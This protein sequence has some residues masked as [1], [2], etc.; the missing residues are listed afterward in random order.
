M[1]HQKPKRH[2]AVQRGRFRTAEQRES[3]GTEFLSQSPAAALLTSQTFREDEGML[4]TC[5]LAPVP[6][7]L[8]H[9]AAIKST[10]DVFLTWHFFSV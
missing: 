5:K 2:P 4:H 1:F 9:F 3:S 6:T 10:I 7:F 8:R